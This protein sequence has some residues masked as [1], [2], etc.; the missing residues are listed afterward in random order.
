[1]DFTSIINAAVSAE[2]D[3]PL[4]QKDI[5]AI[6]QPLRNYL[7]QYDREKQLPINYRDLHTYKYADAIRDTNGK[8]THWETATYDESFQ[9]ILHQ[10]LKETYLLLTGLNDESHTLQ[11][12]TID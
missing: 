4:M 1:M 7:L 12:T 6:E 8:L 11:I 9:E 2:A 3:R 10:Q 5:Y